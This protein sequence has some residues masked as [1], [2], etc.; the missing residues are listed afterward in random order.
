[1]LILWHLLFYMQ[2]EIVSFH[3]FIFYL[4]CFL[5][6]ITYQL[7]LATLFS[8]SFTYALSVTVVELLAELLSTKF[9]HKFW[10]VD[11]QVPSEW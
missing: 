4:F 5:L 1:M 2:S 8:P 7:P 10:D 9:L 3:L 11:L 6:K